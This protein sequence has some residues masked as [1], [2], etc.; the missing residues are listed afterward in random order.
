MLDDSNAKEMEAALREEEELDVPDGMTLEEWQR[1]QEEAQAEEEFIADREDTVRPMVF[2]KKNEDGTFKTIDTRPKTH[3]VDASDGVLGS[4]DLE[5]GFGEPISNEEELRK[6]SVKDDIDP[7]SKTGDA[8]EPVAD[9]P[10]EDSNLGGDA[11]AEEPVA[12]DSLD[13]AASTDEPAAEPEAPAEEPATEEAPAAEE[14]PAEEAPAE[15]TPAEEAPAEDPMREGVKEASS[16]DIPAATDTPTP[17]PG[18][19]PTS[20]VT[21]DAPA[22]QPAEPKKK[23]KTGLIIGLIIA[24]LLIAGGIVGAILFINA[25]E[26]P[27]QK[28]KDAVSNIFRAKT[29]GAT[30]VGAIESGKLPYIGMNVKSG[31]TEMGEMSMSFDFAIKGTGTFY[32]KVGGLDAVVDNLMKTMPTGDSSSQEM[33]K[34]ITD[35]VLNPVNNKWIALDFD[36]EE[37]KATASCMSESMSAVLSEGFRNK[38]GD[39][40]E[41]YP[42]VKYKKDSK[43][44]NRNGIDY[45]EVEIDD[46]LSEKFSKELENADELKTFESCTSKFTGAGTATKTSARKVTETVYDD[47]GLDWDDDAGDHSSPIADIAKDRTQTIKFGIS[48]WSHELQAIEVISED[49][50]GKKDVANFT[51]KEI[52]EGDVKDA[53]SIEDIVKTIMNDLPDVLA[54]Y[55]CEAAMEQMDEE[56]FKEYYGSKK[57]CIDVTKEELGEQ[58]N[59]NNMLGGISTTAIRHS[60]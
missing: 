6:E 29:V 38:A 32:L 54:E 22:V 58:F 57:E 47:E 55:G 9:A 7:I 14:K 23:K 43:V 31:S 56:D 51:F 41:K 15:E 50:D 60:I 48:S 52:S 19:M 5:T 46:E 25:H 35:I 53:K 39:A 40:F 8:A 27:E 36:D 34:K 17:I 28:V 11:V 24:V 20:P 10:V 42:F 21:A 44:E 26:A 3:S 49:K 30:K 4:G 37:V 59:I 45:Y 16:A 18:G 1:I 2:Q 33:N 13:D 12:T